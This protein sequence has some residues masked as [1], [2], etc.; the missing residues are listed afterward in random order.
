MTKKQR[1]FHKR[2]LFF[3]EQLKIDL[4]LKNLMVRNDYS[5]RLKS[6]KKE[7]AK[8]SMIVPDNTISADYSSVSPKTVHQN[9][10]YLKE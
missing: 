8:Y 10:N 7:E 1:N 3:K 6:L 9:R 2:Y 5:Q 4:D